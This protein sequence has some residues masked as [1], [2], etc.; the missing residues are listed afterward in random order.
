MLLPNLHHYSNL[1]LSKSNPLLWNVSY[2]D[3]ETNLQTP[4]SL[5]CSYLFSKLHGS[6][7]IRKAFVQKLIELW[8]SKLFLAV[9]KKIKEKKIIKIFINGL[10]TLEPQENQGHIQSSTSNNESAL[11]ECKLL[12]RAGGEFHSHQRVPCVSECTCHRSAT[13]DATQHDN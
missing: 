9:S 1:S 13:L 6:C 10:R 12:L 8:G 4:G 3:C 7:R 11:Y 5:I 2:F